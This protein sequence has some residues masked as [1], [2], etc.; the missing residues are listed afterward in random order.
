MIPLDHFLIVSALLFAIGLYA[1]LTKKN[2]IMVLVGVELMINASVLNLVAFG[3]YDKVLF[4]G[5]VFALFVIVLAAASVAVAL[6]IVLQV[7]RHFKSVDPTD[8]DSLK[9]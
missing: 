9:D 3:R 2:T 1:T 6:G 7:Y 8:F 4:G 5:Q